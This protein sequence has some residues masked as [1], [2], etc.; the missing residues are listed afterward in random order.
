MKYTNCEHKLSEFL[1][2]KQSHVNNKWIKKQYYT[3]P[4]SHPYTPFL[5][6]T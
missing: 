6:L 1:Q 4:R 3:H 5:S 2:T